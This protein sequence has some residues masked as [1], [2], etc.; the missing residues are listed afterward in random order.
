M[1]IGLLALFAS[2]CGGGGETTPAPAATAV[3]SASLNQINPMPR[4][5]VQD[6]GTFTWPIGQ[7]PSQ[8]NY[9]ELDGT[10]QDNKDVMF[11]MMPAAFYS[12]ASATPKWNPN[13]LAS[14]PVLVAEPKQ[15]VTYVINPKAAWYDGTPITWQDFYWQWKATNGTDKAYRISAA[16]GYE[17]IENVARG[18]DDRE[19][20]VTFKHHFADWQGIF[21]PLF[22]M[23]TNKDPK[24]F[25]D[26]WLQ[27]PLTSA[28]PFKLDKVDQTAKTITLVRNEKWWGNPAKLDRIVFRAI[29]SIAQIDALANGE[30]DAMDIG[31]DA[32][33]F[34]R[35]KTLPNIEIRAAGGPNFRHITINGTSA[36]LQDVQVRQALAMAID[37][38]TIA[39]ALLAPLGR[40]PQPLGN[41]VFM[42][43]QTG[44]KDNSGDL[45]KYDPAK[46]RQLLDAAGW[47]LDGTVRKK[48]G[49]PLE[50][51][52]VIPAGVAQSK[53]ESELVQNML[54]QV[55]VAVKISTVPGN[56]FFDKYIRPG[57]YDFTVFS[58]M[59]TSFPIS[60]SKSVYVKPTKDAKGQLEIQQNYARVG[61]DEIDTLFLQANQELDR[62]KAAELAN[63]ADALI[64][65][66]VHSLTIYQRP[67]LVG[68][69]K[70]LVNFG[71]F[72]FADWVYEDIGWAKP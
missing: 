70:T 55:G 33:M 47:K 48:D 44:Y 61:S 7:I 14:E 35:A 49:K 29:D 39:K 58:W 67:E 37:R 52:F 2:A 42:T 9:Y 59:G 18:K 60:S 12:D 45:G 26:G 13:L 51:T 1:T 32:N 6:G 71:A 10:L 66:E 31:P 69:K 40:D 16:N 62:Q 65:N 24:I 64:W 21:F 27:R 50:I 5:R 63:R 54:A 43:N 34:N 19:V 25:N 53:A 41:H 38:T 57:Q 3:P 30:I 17:D 15:V 28:G 4:E 23:S 11:A 8:F 72:G 46:A 36:N 56:V 22:P 68:S 20:I